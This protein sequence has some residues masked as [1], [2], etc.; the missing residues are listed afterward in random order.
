[1]PTSPRIAKLIDAFIGN[2][3]DV[4]PDL[5]RAAQE[6][7]EALDVGAAATRLVGRGEIEQAEL[8][9]LSVAHAQACCAPDDAGRVLA[10][11]SVS[12][13]VARKLPRSVSDYR[14]LAM[15]AGRCHR[16]LSAILGDSA[17]MQRTRHGV[18]AACFG[19]SLRHMLDLEHVIR[20][21]DVLILGETGTGKEALARA[22]QAATPGAADGS[23]APGGAINA[24]AIPETLVE[25]ELFGHVKGAFTGASETRTGRLRSADGGAF[26][27]D[28]V[29]DLPQT[30]QVKLLRVIETDEV[31]PLGSDTSFT[32]DLRYIAATHKDLEAMV[33]ERQFRQDLF[34]RLAGTVIRIPPLRDRPEDMVEIGLAFVRNNLE[35][36][37]DPER[38]LRT[39]RSWL[40][41]PEARAYAW[42][43]NV[44]ELQNALRSLLLGLRPEIHAGSPAQQPEEEEMPAAVLDSTWS[45]SAVKDWYVRRVLARCGGNYTRAAQILGVDRSTV[46]RAARPSQ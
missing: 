46:R 41:G 14:R 22:I 13:D 1:M 37:R 29:G 38:Q 27:L 26:F 3:F 23:R 28:E 17:P 21:H 8:L 11:G 30:T 35:S 16:A 20:D 45:L 40:R 36:V 44:R 42:P 39:I 5:R 31:Q 25:S 15:A 7:L 32:V 4:D 43:G 24:A 18:W 6:V 12:A 19:N 33:E 34:Q 10:R 2:P 9:L